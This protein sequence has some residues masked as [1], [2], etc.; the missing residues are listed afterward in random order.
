MTR[1]SSGTFA[2]GFGRET[3]AD[4]DAWLARLRAAEIDYVMSFEPSSMELRWME[5]Q[6]ARFER[7]AGDRVRWGL[8]RVL[9]G[10]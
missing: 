2:P 8:Y 10:P 4:R 1:S 3:R 6:P 5:S 7:V 9:R